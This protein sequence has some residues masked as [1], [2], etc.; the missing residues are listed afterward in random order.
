MRNIILALAL[1]AACVECRLS[2]QDRQWNTEDVRVFNCTDI[3]EKECEYCETP[4][5]CSD[6]ESKCGEEPPV[7][8]P[9]CPPSEV[10]VPSG[11]EC[12]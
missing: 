12:K 11:C 4:T 1:F 6:D 9:D 5:T 2:A 10:C 3:C 7:L 8:G